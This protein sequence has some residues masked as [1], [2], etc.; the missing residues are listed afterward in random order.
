MRSSILRNDIFTKGA[1]LGAVMLVSHIAELSMIY[2]GHSLIWAL[3][4][5][6]EWLL[7]TGLYFVLAYFFTRSFARKVV[8]IREREKASVPEFTYLDGL[9]YIVQISMLAG[10]IVAIGSHLYMHNVVGYNE[11]ITANIE[12]LQES[13]MAS[14]MAMPGSL[15]EMIQVMKEATEPTIIESLI[16]SI[17]NYMI[18]GV[19][20]GAIVAIVTKRRSN[21]ITYI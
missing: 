7:V 10:V 9:L 12:M 6:F 15:Q 4:A 3:I 8:I 20:V 19:F 5:T 14:R 2:Y 16:G 17:W 18:A 21:K 1:I 11:Y 13:F